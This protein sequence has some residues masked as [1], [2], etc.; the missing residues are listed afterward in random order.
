MAAPFAALPAT[1]VSSAVGSP[2]CIE[3]IIEY[4]KPHP[5]TVDFVHQPQHH[6]Q[7]QQQQQPSHLHHHPVPQVVHY[8]DGATSNVIT[9]TSSGCG[10][11]L[12]NPVNAAS[13]GSATGGHNELLSVIEAIGAGSAGGGSAASSGGTSAGEVIPIIASSG[14][15]FTFI[16]NSI[17]TTSAGVAG[18]IV[19]AGSGLLGAGTITSMQPVGLGTVTKV[20]SMLQPATLQIATPVGGNY[21]PGANPGESKHYVYQ[22]IISFVYLFD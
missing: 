9:P 5:A 10:A 21:A 1:S 12:V 2:A 22:T 3:E 14:T 4:P 18:A 16:G 6:Q 17:A 15:N 13:S 7:P 20:Q 8:V 11:V 19:P